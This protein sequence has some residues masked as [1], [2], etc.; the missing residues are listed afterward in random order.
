MAN[1]FFS[2]SHS[3]WFNPKVVCVPPKRFNVKL[4]VMKCTVIKKYLFIF[5]QITTKSYIDIYLYFK[6]LLKNVIINL[7][8][9]YFMSNRNKIKRVN[10]YTVIYCSVNQ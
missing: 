2:Q 4:N 1:Y 5:I 9:V 3:F 8:I 10:L 7:I 6:I